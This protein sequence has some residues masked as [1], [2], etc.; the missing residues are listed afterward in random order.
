MTQEVV[1]TLQ[2]VVSGLADDTF[3]LPSCRLSA[4]NSITGLVRGNKFDLT[5]TERGELL[6]SLIGK[7]SRVT[8]ETL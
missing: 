6:V 3:L 8:S 1:R 5:P 4:I 7:L 2:E